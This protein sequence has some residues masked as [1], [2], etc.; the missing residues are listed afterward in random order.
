MVSGSAH[1][2]AMTQYGKQRRQRLR[3][4]SPVLTKGKGYWELKVFPLKL[5]LLKGYLQTSGPPYFSLLVPGVGEGPPNLRKNFLAPSSA[6]VKYP[7]E[8]LLLILLEFPSDSGLDKAFTFM[9]ASTP[10]Q[11][12][13]GSVSCLETSPPV[14]VL[15][16]HRVWTLL[17]LT[18]LIN[19]LLPLTQHGMSIYRALKQRP[20]TGKVATRFDVPVTSDSARDDLERHLWLVVWLSKPT[21]VW[22]P[23]KR[24]TDLF[25][26]RSWAKHPHV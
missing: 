8:R 20:K 12:F 3:V 17:S 25:H 26:C 16:Y 13:F 1:L 6:T 7:N 14:I 19:L 9:C 24:I 22:K 2:L 10:V 5:K 4:S 11:R 21:R 18:L 15:F 23:R